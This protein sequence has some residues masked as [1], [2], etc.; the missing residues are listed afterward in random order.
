MSMFKRVVLVNTARLSRHSVESLK[1]PKT[2]MFNITF[3]QQNFT[4]IEVMFATVIAGVGVLALIPLMYVIVTPGKN[5]M[6]ETR[7]SLLAT[8][9][10]SKIGQE[11]QSDWKNFVDPIDG[12][13]FLPVKSGGTFTSTVPTDEDNIMSKS[14]IGVPS[15]TGMKTNASTELPG[16]YKSME[17]SFEAGIRTWQEPL[18]VT[19]L[20]S[21]GEEITVEVDSQSAIVLNAEVTWPTSVAY[22]HRRRWHYQY[23]IIR[24]ND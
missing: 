5:T 24:P 4:L 22:S 18:A 1:S 6:V 20:A 8:K 21:D 3:H 17:E 13:P 10:T 7:I 2:L 11:I 9:F 16:H 19:M 23:V 12:S 14:M 15:V